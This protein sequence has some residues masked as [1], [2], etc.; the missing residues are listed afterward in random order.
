MK[1][2]LSIDQPLPGELIVSDNPLARRTRE[3]FCGYTHGADQQTVS[4]VCMLYPENQTSTPRRQTIDQ[5]REVM[6]SLPDGLGPGWLTGE[7]ILVVDGFRYVEQ[8]GRRL[9]LWST[10][11]LGLTIIVCFRSI[12]WVIIPILVVQL[13]L[14]STQAVL[15]LARL[16]LSMVSSMLTAVVMVIGVATM[17]H[18]M[19][20]Y[21]ESRQEGLSP[22][23][24]L[25]QTLQQLLIPVFWACLTDAAGFM[26]LTVSDVGPVRDFGIMMAVGSLMVL[27]S[28][29][30]LVPGLTVFGRFDPDPHAPWGEGRLTRRLQQLLTAVDRRPYR[31]LGALAVVSVLAM[32]GISRLKVET[33]FTRNFRQDSDIAQAYNFVEDHLGGAGVCDVMIPAPEKLHWSVLQAHLSLGPCDFP[34]TEG[35]RKPIWPRSPSRLA[36]RMRWSICRRSRSPTSLAWYSTVSS[37]LGSGR[38]ADGCRSSM[39]P[40]MVKIRRPASTTCG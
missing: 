28:V 34:T 35:S 30:L 37:F 18:I 7:P 9:G 38:C 16:E 20:R 22:L 11:L 6:N 15:V 10:L 19:V 40:C 8:D 27:V 33:D 13:A 23:E 29:V 26:A 31:V 3:L 32:A 5:L 25:R 14:I 24:S 1:A 36:W 39:M 17:V 12:R 2:V 21:A 4:V